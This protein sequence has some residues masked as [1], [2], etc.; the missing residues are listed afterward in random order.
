METWFENNFIHTGQT[1]FLSDYSDNDNGNTNLKTT[2]TNYFQR[3]IPLYEVQL[4]V[5]LKNNLE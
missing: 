3:G 4:S 5:P 1:A 2:K